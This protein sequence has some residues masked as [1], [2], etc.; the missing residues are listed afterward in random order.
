MK[1]ENSIINLVELKTIA[2]QH[3]EMK[4]YKN[5]IHYYRMAI[6]Q[7]LAIIQELLQ[8]IDYCMINLEDPKEKE[9]AK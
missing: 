1:Q 4:R 8:E 5:A 9:D 7:S 2:K 6:N 3:V